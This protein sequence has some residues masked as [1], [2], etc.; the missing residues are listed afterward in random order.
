[1]NWVDQLQMASWRG[2]PFKTDSLE[3]VVG[4]STVVRDYPFQDLPTTQDMGTATD[5]IRIAGYVIGDD[6]ITQRDALIK[7]LRGSGVLVHPTRGRIRCTVKGGVKVRE[8]PTQEGGI[9]RFELVFIRGESRRYPSALPS[10]K[11]QNIEAI[12]QARPLL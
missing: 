3:F 8:N 5:E 12:E 11:S 4:G 6:Y 1:M 9:A 2:V 10:T 7:V